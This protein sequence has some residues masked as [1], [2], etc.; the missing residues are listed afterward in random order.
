REAAGDEKEMVPYTP[1]AMAQ[2]FTAL[3]DK[4]HPLAI[5]AIEQA[6]ALSKLIG[7]QCLGTHMDPQKDAEK[8][9]KI[10][11]RL[12]D[13]Y[14]SHEYEISR[15]E[16]REVGLNVVDPTDEEEK[17]MMDL[18]RFYSGRVFLPFSKEQPPT[19]GGQRFQA[20]IAWLDST[21]LTTRAEGNYVIGE[22]G[23]S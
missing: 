6:Y 20:F 12:C 21:A 9:T 2:I 1:E 16:A 3:F 14:K 15:S 18:F 19:I 22:G 5:G 4:I 8:I 13:D 7:T 11:N 17:A 10:V 23:Q